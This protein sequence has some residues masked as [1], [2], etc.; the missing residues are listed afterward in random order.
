MHVT[1]LLYVIRCAVEKN[2]SYGNYIQNLSKYICAHF[3]YD[4]LDNKLA[5]VA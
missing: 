1:H 3:L 4:V 2:V 5:Q